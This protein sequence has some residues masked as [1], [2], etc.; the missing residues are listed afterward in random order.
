MTQLKFSA[1]I[2]DLKEKVMGSD[3]E[4]MVK[5]T[6]VLILNECMEQERE[7]Y[8]QAAAYERTT[9][10]V[11][12]RNG[13]YERE[14]I[15]SLG[16]I[17]LTVPRTRFGDFSPSIFERY[18]RYDQAFVM[19]ML[20]MFVNGVSTRKVTKIVNTLCGETVSKSF[21]S[22]LTKKLDPI[23]NEWAQRPLHT[24]TL[25]FVFVDA[26]YIKVRE[27][28][29]VVSKAVYIAIALDDEGYRHILGLHISHSENEEAWQTFFQ[30][31]IGRGVSSPKLV[32]SDAH[33]GL[34]NAI[35]KSFIGTSWQR[36]TVHFK[37]NI[38]V[39][40]PKEGKKE[41]IKLL[42]QI[43]DASSQKEARQLRDQFLDDYGDQ[44]SFQK[45][46]K[47]LDEGFEDAIQ[48][49]GDAIP[50]NFKTHV[51][52]TNSLERL[53]QEVRRREKIIRIFPNTQ[54]AFRLVGATLMAYEEIIKHNPKKFR[55]WE[56]K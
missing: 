27:N 56:N 40:M 32:V 1:N 9:E 49:L 4:T 53:N 51:R 5:S 2:E 33:N 24:L 46:C 11:D 23:V 35:Q 15:M 52:S 22:N 47:V 45:A 43:F 20:E 12:Y 13:Y 17:K 18:A 50:E 6:I 21:V 37:R 30:Q 16:S 38:I 39:K 34:V 54:S 42:K 28:Q 10:R 44:P 41:A 25:D 7:D 36:C 14:L 29:K 26:L 8:L 48:Y 19:S 3:L 55:I 31:L